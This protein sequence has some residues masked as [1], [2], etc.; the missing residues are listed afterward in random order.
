M[1]RIYADGDQP[2][3]PDPC[4]LPTPHLHF[5]GRR[6]PVHTS[7]IRQLH[8][9]SRVSPTARLTANLRGARASIGSPM[10][11]ATIKHTAAPPQH[12]KKPKNL[13]HLDSAKYLRRHQLLRRTTLSS[14]NARFLLIRPVPAPHWNVPRDRAAESCE[15]V[16]GS[17]RL[18]C[19]A[20]ARRD[21]KSVV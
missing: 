18:S 3:A 10:K 19:C 6:R 8:F 14:D 16:R 11:K 5:Q 12:I 21:R 7:A 13:S 1:N 4:Q 20:G 17:V 9:S 15:G 2:S